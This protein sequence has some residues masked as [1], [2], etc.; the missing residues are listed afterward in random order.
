MDAQPQLTDQLT[1][2]RLRAA[3][4]ESQLHQARAELHRS[5]MS[6]ARSHQ[7][8]AEKDQLIQHQRKV[9]A[10]LEEA[11]MNEPFFEPMPAIAVREWPFEAKATVM[12]HAPVRADFLFASPCGGKG[13]VSILGCRGAVA[14]IFQRLFPEP[15]PPPKTEVRR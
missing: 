7:R 4:A 8:E 14:E 5:E 6:C 9:M 11:L 10:E 2:A 3:E 12:L 1:A 13:A 15:E